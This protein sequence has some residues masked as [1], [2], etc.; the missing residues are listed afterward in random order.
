MSRTRL[1]GQGHPSRPCLA[2]HASIHPMSFP[3]VRWTLIDINHS[4]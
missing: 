3:T 4:W 1:P 2:P